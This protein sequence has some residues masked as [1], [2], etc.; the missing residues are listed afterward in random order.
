[1]LAAAM[2]CA[3][4]QSSLVTDPQRGATPT[5]PPPR[6]V[7]IAPST[8]PAPTPAPTTAPPPPIL[9]Q[10]VRGVQP[11]TSSTPQELPTSDGNVLPAPSA[12][13]LAIDPGSDPILRLARESGDPLVF[14]QSIQAAVGRHPSIAE[15]E[16][17]RDEA[18]AARNEARTLEL[19]VIDM[20]LSYFR[21]V[22]RAFTDDPQNVLER[23]RPTF[24]T[25]E[26]LRLQA[27]VFDFGSAKSRIAAGNRRL[28]ASVAGIDDVSVQLALRGVD[29]WYRVFGY[30]ALVGLAESFLASQTE[31]RAAIAERVEQGV[32]APG[33]VAQVESYIAA[34]Q[35]QLAGFKRSLANAEA[36]YRQVIGV[37]APPGLG[38]APTATLVPT[39]RE[40]AEADS[41]NIPAVEAARLNAVAARE[42]ARA[43]RGDALPG[44]GVGVDAGR[45]GLLENAG[46]YDVR[47][48]VTLTQRL[49]GGATQRIDQAKARARGAGATYDRIRVEA[50]RDAAIA[51]SDVEALAES[52]AAIENNYIATRQSRD[53][54][55]ERFRVS[56]GTLFDVLS[57]ETNYFNVASRYIETVTELDIARYAL[58]ARTGKLLDGFGIAPA[59]LEAR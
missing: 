20:S 38:R 48:S 5:P 51:W 4:A 1:M 25:D 26:T 6:A 34:A 3:H 55:V 21:T 50:A 52:A 7:P 32:S 17:R 9:L 19:P 30:R 39:S 54:L 22:D 47:A 16:A 14:R 23:S 44:L 42:D 43:A 40:R 37:P 35:T 41:Q 27:P 57:A 12:D 56:R 53:V 24:R 58:L 10:P 59:R 28:E 46:D 49:F 13:P 18:R 45:Y 8:S 2:P 36:Q 11:D 31:L 29:S 33:D 15:A